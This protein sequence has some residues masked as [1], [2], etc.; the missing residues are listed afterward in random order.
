VRVGIFGG[1]FNPIHFGHLRSAEEIR[2]ALTLNHTYFV[3]SAIPPHKER[4]D[5]VSAHHRLRMV[6]LA[7]ADHPFFSPSAVELERSGKSFSVDTIRHF[8][9]SLSPAALYFIMGLDA[10]REIHT[11]KDYPTIFS[12]CHVIVTSRPGCPEVPL[13]QLIPVALRGEFCYDPIARRCMHTSGYALAFCPITGLDISASAIRQR[14]QQGKSIR[15]L[16]PRQVEEYIAAHR[17]YQSGAPNFAKEEN[18]RS[19]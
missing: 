6:E 7:V 1:T 11:W 18:D 14:I 8:L 15:Y 17:L 4:T 19:R 9:T 3:P 2:E 12:L 5:L 16:V 10:F 13:T